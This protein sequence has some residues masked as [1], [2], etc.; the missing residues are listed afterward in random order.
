MLT[1]AENERL[2]RVGTG[3]PMGEMLRE[4]WTPA[5]AFVDSKGTPGVSSPSARSSASSSSDF[6]RA[7]KLRENL[8][9]PSR[10]FLLRWR[11]SG[12][13]TSKDRLIGNVPHQIRDG[14]QIPIRFG[15]ALMTEIGRQRYHVARDGITTIRTGLEGPGREGVPQRLGG[16]PSLSRSVW[17]KKRRES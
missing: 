11:P 1:K 14:F 6:N 10:S 9:T 8:S 17:R 4:F 16:R 3:T 13:G 15:H 12:G 7:T 5:I 2:T